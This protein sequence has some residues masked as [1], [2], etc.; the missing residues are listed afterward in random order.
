VERGTTANNAAAE[1]AAVLSQKG[2]IAGTYTAY[3]ATEDLYKECAKQADYKITRA[4]DSDAEMPK[5]EDGEDLG[6]GEGWWH[7]GKHL[8]KKILMV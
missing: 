6:V 3:G 4:E 5:T 8:N 1:A 2:G 7:T